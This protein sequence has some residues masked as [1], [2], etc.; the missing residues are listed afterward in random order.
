MQ[1][2]K[3]SSKMTLLF[4]SYVCD[5][6]EPPKNNTTKIIDN[7]SGFKYYIIWTASDMRAPFAAWQYFYRENLFEHDLSC[8]VRC[9]QY[10]RVFEVFT[11]NELPFD[12]SV[13]LDFDDSNPSLNQKVCGPTFRAKALREV[14]DQVELRR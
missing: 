8:V 5:T 9:Y 6:C 4:M 13:I 7:N 10:E 2:N 1:C 11:E 14:T 12:R 3:C